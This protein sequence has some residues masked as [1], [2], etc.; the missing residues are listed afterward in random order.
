MSLATTASVDLSLDDVF[1]Y[2]PD[3][4]CDGNRFSRSRR[5]IA[6]LRVDAEFSEQLLA[7]RNGRIKR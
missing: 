2:I 5:G 3:T 6:T 1:L 4:E 7:C